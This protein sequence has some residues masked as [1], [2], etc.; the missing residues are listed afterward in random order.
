MG[1]TIYRKAL[2]ISTDQLPL[3]FTEQAESNCYDSMGRN[4]YTWSF[5]GI[6]SQEQFVAETLAYRDKL[7]AKNAEFQAKYPNWGEYKD[8]QFGWY[9]AIQLDGKEAGQTSLADYLAI[10]QKAPIYSVEELPYSLKLE[11]K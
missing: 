11:P 6:K 1:N 8:A 10:F 4:P 2:W 9:A 3:L 7:A 5:Q